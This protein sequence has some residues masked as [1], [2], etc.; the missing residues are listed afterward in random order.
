MNCYLCSQAGGPGGTRL[1]IREAVGTCHYCGIGICELH[2]RRRP[3]PSGPFCCPTHGGGAPSDHRAAVP[4][5][6]TRLPAS[7]GT[8]RWR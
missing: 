1:G 4:R 7:M 5:G 8:G 6:R 3:E 2:G